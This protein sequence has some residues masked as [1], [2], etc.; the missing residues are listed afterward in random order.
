MR[1]SRWIVAGLIAVGLG[2]AG[3]SAADG[4]GTGVDTTADSKVEDIAGKDVKQITLTAHAA[5]RLGIATVSIGG[6][7]PLVAA[8]GPSTGP[9]TP[10]TVIPYSAVL[11]APDGSTW[12]YTVPKPLTYV[13]EKV[14]V[15]VVRGAKGDEAVLSLAPPA[16]TTIVSTGVV[17]LYG[18]ELGIGNVTE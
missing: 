2:L 6:S 4:G 3:C 10:L 17:E 1:T 8:P 5:Q 7:V 13:R 18:T 12:V 14:V 16:G 11:Y 9:A 15:Q